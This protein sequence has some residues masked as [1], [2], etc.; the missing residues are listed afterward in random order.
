MEPQTENA[1]VLEALSLA[2]RIIL[3]SGGETYRVEDTVARMGRA[4]GAVKA[5][6]FAVTSGV[7]MTVQFPDGGVETT[8]HRSENQTINLARVNAVNQI[9]RQAAAGK[10][11]PRE[12]LSALEKLQN[13]KPEYSFV[14]LLGAAA[15]SAGGFAVMFGGNWFDF[16]VSFFSGAAIQAV[17]I[18]MSGLPYSYV[19]KSLLGGMLCMLLPLLLNRAFGMGTVDAMVAGTLMPLLPGLA[20]TNAVQD[21]MRGDMLAGVGHATHAILTAAFVAGG[22]VMANRLF[23]MLFGG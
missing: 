17:L 2:G 21:G 23:S 1:C 22:A 6:A 14:W 13:G 16:V 18:A 10:I 19:V 11:T 8:V 5:E 15:I 3:E 20:M 7:F 12:A 9:S 4:F